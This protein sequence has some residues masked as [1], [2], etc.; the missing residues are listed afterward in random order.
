[1]FDYTI[2]QDVSCPR[3]EA[4]GRIDALSAAELHQ[5][6]QQLVLEGARVLL[7]DLSAVQYISSAGLRVF[8]TTQKE[9]KKVGGEMLLAGL[10]PQVMDVFR[11]SGV[12][13]LFRIVSGTGDF[14]MQGL[15]PPSGKTIRSA[16]VTLEYLE[17]Q[18]KTGSLLMIGRTDKME[19]AGYGEGDV[20][21][22]PASRMRSGCG[23]AALG[24]RFD[25]YR[26]YFGEAMVINGSFFYYPAC[27]HPSVDFMLGAQSNPSVGY[28]FLHGFGVNGED[29][30]LLSF[31]SENESMDLAELAGAF[32]SVSS[33]P[34]IGVTFLA[35][36]RGIWGMNIRKTPVAAGQM[37][38]I[39][40]IFDSRSFPDWF[41]FPIE[42]SYTGSVVAATGI[43]ARN[44]RELPG[45]IQTL[46]SGG[47][48]FHVHG[49]IFGKA[50]VSNRLQ[51]LD[52]ELMRIFG[53]LDALKIQHLLGQ[54]RFA[55]GLAGLVEIEV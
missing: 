50:P 52:H 17:T 27:R 19:T 43:V 7:A 13:L 10:P 26:N 23:L 53:E 15:K 35:E 49:A 5:V 37:V 55:G 42:P 14:G 38:A 1:M 33:A 29:R 41:D 20:T 30:Y 16:Q 12:D 40:S 11:V 18:A 24:D 47:N 6:F 22:V 25:D 54:S 44:P 48:M 4:K 2:I 31:K 51:D 21:D 9:L 8:I 3:V 32:L 28:K 36:S 46:F 34:L 39:E 45:G